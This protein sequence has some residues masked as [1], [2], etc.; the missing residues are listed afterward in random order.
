M[1]EGRDGPL[2]SADVVDNKTA[3]NHTTACKPWNAEQDLVGILNT[4]AL[5]VNMYWKPFKFETTF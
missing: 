3:I 5:S 1:I 2:I 4:V